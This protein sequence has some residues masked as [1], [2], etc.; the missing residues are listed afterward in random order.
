MR[1][2]LQTHELVKMGGIFIYL[3]TFIPISLFL[4]VI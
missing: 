2:S 1:I 3:L 4:P